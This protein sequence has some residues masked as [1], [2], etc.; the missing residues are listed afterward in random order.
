[1]F[2]ST[3]QAHL[4]K[5]LPRTALAFRRRKILKLRWMQTAT[6]SAPTALRERVRLA[7]APMDAASTSKKVIRLP[8][9]AANVILIRWKSYVFRARLPLRA[10]DTAQQNSI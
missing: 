8:L 9:A 4:A 1:M 7:I 5:L 6:K 3:P 2:R 10:S